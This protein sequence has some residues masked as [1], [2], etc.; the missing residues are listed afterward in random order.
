M[1]DDGAVVSHPKPTPDPYQQC[2]IKKSARSDEE[3]CIHNV[4]LI[5]EMMDQ[6]KLEQN[7]PP[8]PTAIRQPQSVDTSASKLTEEC[9]IIC[10][11]AVAA[12]LGALIR[13]GIGG[14]YVIW[15]TASIN[16]SILWANLFGSILMGF[17][18][19]HVSYFKLSP[20]RFLRIMYPILTTGLC[21]S[22]TTFSSWS[23]ECNKSF[24]LEWQGKEDL[25]S[26]RGGRI[27]EWI[28]SMW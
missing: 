15:D 4:G 1:A 18:T 7:T 24:F 3:K 26:L 14:Y 25:P 2:S 16:Y 19:R 9:L 11:L 10:G 17:V 23:F 20:S 27:I 5:C 12:Y 13:I 8:S 21:G 22:I 28:V 6:S